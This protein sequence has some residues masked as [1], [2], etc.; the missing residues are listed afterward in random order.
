MLARHGFLA[1]MAPPTAL[2][3]QISLHNSL[4]AGILAWRLVRS[5]LDRQ[6]VWVLEN[7]TAS[8]LKGPP[9]AGLSCRLSLYRDRIRTT[10]LRNR[11]SVS[12]QPLKNSR[13][14]ETRSRDRRIKPLR[15]RG[16]SQAQAASILLKP[17]TAN[18]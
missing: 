1:K 9:I 4:L 16:V 15:G 12:I 18:S 2:I 14:L 6:P 10:I 5:A 3:S 17:V 13:F 7:I 11:G 8:I